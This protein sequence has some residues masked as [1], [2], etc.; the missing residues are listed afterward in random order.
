[1]KRKRV[2]KRCFVFCTHQMNLASQTIPLL[3]VDSKRSGSKAKQENVLL[4][5]VLE[6]RRTPSWR[7]GGFLASSRKE[8]VDAIVVYEKKFDTMWRRVSHPS[9][10]SSTAQAYYVC[11]L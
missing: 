6:E 9:S 8:E 10:R 5:L 11:R 7:R 4:Q 3:R 1:M 2:G